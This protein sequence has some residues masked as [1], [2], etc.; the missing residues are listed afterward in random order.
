VAEANCARDRENKLSPV[1]AD[2]SAAVR[3]ATKVWRKGRGRGRGG[4]GGLDG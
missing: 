1:A 3:A 2:N 4:R